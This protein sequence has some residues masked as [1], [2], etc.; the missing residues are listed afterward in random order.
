[1]TDR[2]KVGSSGWK[3]KLGEAQSHRKF[4]W[5]ITRVAPSTVSWRRDEVKCVTASTLMCR[6]M[7]IWSPDKA[8]TLLKR[9]IR[10]SGMVAVSNQITGP[11]G[12]YCRCFHVQACEL[13]VHCIQAWTHVPIVCMTSKGLIKKMGGSSVL[14]T[15][16]VDVLINL[17]IVLSI[18]FEDVINLQSHLSKYFYSL[19][20]YIKIW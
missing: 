2:N 13:Y 16:V 9:V 1:M 18:V 14:L 7:L 11:H 6:L 5:G 4:F 8:R 15:W 17:S 19:K 20:A 3:H 12:L 10:D